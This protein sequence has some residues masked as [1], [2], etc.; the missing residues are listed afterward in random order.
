MDYMLEI[1]LLN[2]SSQIQMWN[3]VL[4]STSIEALNEAV[5]KESIKKFFKGILEFIQKYINIFR[6][7]VAKITKPIRE[8]INKV[9]NNFLSKQL[10]RNTNIPFNYELKE[11]YPK[12]YN[13]ALKEADQI[14]SGTIYKAN[15]LKSNLD[16]YLQSADAL[17]I[18]HWVNK[19]PK[20]YQSPEEVESIA[21]M[22]GRYEFFVIKKI[23]SINKN[24][25][26]DAKTIKVNIDDMV[27]GLDQQMIQAA[28]I[29]QEFKQDASDMENKMN[30][31]DNYPGSS[32]ILKAYNILAKSIQIS[33]SLMVELK[34]AAVIAANE[35]VKFIE[36]INTR[37]TRNENFDDARAAKDEEIKRQQQQSQEGQAA[38]A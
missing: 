13:A 12:Y 35:Y 36:A 14:Y 32:N 30:N 11:L 31:G 16:R 15:E 5:N 24:I 38:T 2:E 6:E 34:N 19:Y 37:L 23:K 17:D 27:K 29:M 8:K 10:D 3:Y 22:E 9:Y 4:E 33:G 26:N 18:D 28:K 1:D 20:L 7:W 25:M 21:K